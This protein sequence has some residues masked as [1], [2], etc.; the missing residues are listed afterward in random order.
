MAPLKGERRAS[1][2][3]NVER[4][5]KIQMQY[6]N[7]IGSRDRNPSNFKTIFIAFCLGT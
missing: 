6:F 1:G 4:L 2:V 5:L 7:L 3:Q